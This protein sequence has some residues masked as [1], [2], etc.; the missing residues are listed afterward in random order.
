MAQTFR[1]YQSQGVA[2]NQLNL[3]QGAESI[4]ASKTMQVLSQ[5][6]NR[7]S[8]FAF[9]QAKVEAEI[10]GERFG[11]EFMTDEKVKEAL[12]SNEDIFDLPEFGNTVFG[13]SART[14]ALT[15]LE[16]QITV[17]ATKS[18]NNIIFNGLENNTDPTTI[19]NQLDANIL[20]YVDSMSAS[21]PKLAKKLSA[22]LELQGASEYDSYRKTHL[23]GTT[24]KL[25]AGNLVGLQT[26][27][28]T[29]SSLLE[30]S[31]ANGKLTQ[32]SFDY[33]RKVFA[34]KMDTMGLKKTD[35]KPFVKSVDEQFA[36][37]IKSKAFNHVIDSPSQSAMIRK[38]SRG[39]S[40]GN[41][42]L[43][44]LLGLR[45]VNYDFR[46]KLVTELRTN[47]NSLNAESELEDNRLDDIQK[48][49]LE[50]GKRSFAK[51]TT[52]IINYEEARRAI[53]AVRKLDTDEAD[54]LQLKLNSAQ[55]G[56]RINTNFDD[57]RVPIF[58]KKANLGTATYDDLMEVMDEL[59][60]EDQIKY[61]K[62]IETSLDPDFK[63]GLLIFSEGFNFNP[64]ATIVEDN[65]DSQLRR[66]TFLT[67]RLELERAVRSAKKQNVDIDIEA[68]AEEIKAKYL[69]NFDTKLKKIK[70][71]SRKS[72]L[73]NFKGNFRKL[74]LEI[75]DNDADFIRAII[76][77]IET[78]EGN[79]RNL[80]SMGLSNTNYSANLQKLEELLQEL[81]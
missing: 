70:D 71:K 49:N 29:I 6:L 4:E 48:E 35:A 62:M 14:S 76:Q 68:K 77:Y 27:I 72:Y 78:N 55:G 28:N 40:T 8:E 5:G 31:Y 20:G 32:A 61:E 74:N 3:P 11:V 44:K 23:K 73:L 42:Q 53:D 60:L 13:R 63:Q 81:E 16:N 56:K 45:I 38:I 21:A 22:K 12:R 19:R 26:D 18:M 50:L 24:A 33:V 25:N 7:M 46:Q 69:D 36:S 37:F 67:A 66:Q 79:T 51:F 17:Q 58:I 57:V 9:R 15:V 52:G 43:D 65:E 75:P 64:I 41:E 47:L 34:E 30:P 39:Q 10:E 80:K 1:P 59:N 54:K 2:L